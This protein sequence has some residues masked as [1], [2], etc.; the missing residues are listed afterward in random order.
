MIGRREVEKEEPVG[1]LNQM[2]GGKLSWFDDAAVEMFLKQRGTRMIMFPRAVFD[3]LAGRMNKR[4]TGKEVK[5][6]D[7]GGSG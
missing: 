5:M 2:I 3:G 4:R 6:K 1:V 7:E